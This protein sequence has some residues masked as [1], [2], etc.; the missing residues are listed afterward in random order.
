MGKRWGVYQNKNYL[1]LGLDADRT[2]VWS[3]R[4]RRCLLE[5]ATP[6]SLSTLPSNLFLRW[7][8]KS[9]TLIS[10]VHTLKTLSSKWSLLFLD[11]DLVEFPWTVFLFP[12]DNKMKH[13]KK[14]LKFRVRRTQ[15]KKQNFRVR[16]TQK[17]KFKKHTS[18]TVRTRRFELYLWHLHCLKLELPMYMMKCLSF[19]WK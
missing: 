19:S 16:R 15:K 12:S 17:K 6:F 11:L 7:Q 5:S 4:W 9:C 13:K 10:H 14:K 8:E 18:V 3:K 1:W 2:S